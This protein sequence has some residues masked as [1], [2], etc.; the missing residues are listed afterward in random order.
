MNKAKAATVVLCRCPEGRKTF[1]VRFEKTGNRR[2]KYTWAFPIQDASAKREGY[3]AVTVDGN[4]EADP[5][6][7]GCPY[8]KKSNFIICSCGKLNCFWGVGKQYSC[9]WCGAIFDD[10]SEYDGSG[11]RGGDM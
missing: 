6:Y 7:P 3:D 2:W 4:I 11:F 8:C 10:I 5:N 1:G 9:G